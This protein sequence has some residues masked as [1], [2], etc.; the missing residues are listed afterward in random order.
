[1][2]QAMKSGLAVLILSGTTAMA[3]GFTAP[4]ESPI[5]MA[6]V[7]TVISQDMSDWS[8][9][10][11][12][13]QA[14]KVDGKLKFPGQ[15]ST[16]QSGRAMGVHGGYL[17]DMGQFVLGGELAYNK[18]SNIKADG[19]SRSTDGS[20]LSAKALAGYDLG[21][22]MPYATAGI[23]RVSLDGAG[24]NGADLKDTGY[25]Y[26]LGAKFKATDRIMV[27]AEVLRHDFKDMGK[28]KGTSLDA[29][30]VGVNVGFRF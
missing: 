8:G 29:T 13:I 18:L 25:V 27:G 16:D 11:A 7:E 22:V 17:H 2:M 26:G 6:P 9:A 3:G 5:I 21:R 20:A 28:E 12:G 30:T 15:A 10:Y 23:E 24:P 19:S 14:A 4:V 1:M